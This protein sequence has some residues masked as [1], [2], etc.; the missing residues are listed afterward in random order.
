MIKKFIEKSKQRLFALVAVA[1][2]AIAMV[3]TPGT[4]GAA[5]LDFSSET[6]GISVMDMV[7]SALSFLGIFNDWVLIGLGVI[8]AGVIVGI[9]FWIVG[10]LK[11][12]APGR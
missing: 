5:P 6:V 9:I 2:A 12:H 4:V 11:K 8:F 7:K 1:V 10:K 3:A